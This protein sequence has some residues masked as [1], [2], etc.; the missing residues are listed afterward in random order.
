LGDPTNQIRHSIVYY[1]TAWLLAMTHYFGSLY[2]MILCV[3]NMFEGLV[4]PKRWKSILL[5]I[6]I[7]LWPIYSIVFG[8]RT[9]SQ[10]GMAPWEA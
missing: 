9:H 5:M 10:V 2:I 8:N 1:L 3:I 6:S 4:E 7:L